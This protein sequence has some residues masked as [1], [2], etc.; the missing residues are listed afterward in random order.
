MKNKNMEWNL[1]LQWA[2]SP[3]FTGVIF[4]K[5][6]FVAT[7]MTVAVCIGL[8][9]AASASPVV[10]LDSTY[11]LYLNGSVSG[12]ARDLTSVF[13]AKPSEFSSNGLSLTISEADIDQGNGV[14]LISLTLLATGSLFPDATDSVELGMGV[15]G[16]GLDLVRQ[17]SLTLAT[18]DLFGADGRS[19][20]ALELPID[21]AA[22]W[23]GIYPSLLN[24]ISFFPE[25]IPIFG[26]AFNFTVTGAADPTEPPSGVPEPSSLMLFAAAMFAAGLWQHRRIVG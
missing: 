20:A 9:P 12:N 22:S 8:I 11:S 7:L 6:L 25:G 2:R 18:L 14:N 19:F 24:V 3:R 16:D 17:V 4:M 21:G 13:D 15:F 10:L 1:L 5:N 26:F 23:D